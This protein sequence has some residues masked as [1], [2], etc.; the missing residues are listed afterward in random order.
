M[1]HDSGHIGIGR[2]LS[3]RLLPLSVGVGLL[4]TLLAPATYWLM[5]HREHQRQAN[6]QAEDLAKEFRDLALKSPDLWKY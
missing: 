6:H 3:R 4:I 5:T 2:Y 1:T